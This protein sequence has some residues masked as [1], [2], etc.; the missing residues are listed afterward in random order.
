[1]SNVSLTI[2][3][4]GNLPALITSLTVCKPLKLKL[5][6]RLMLEKPLGASGI[7]FNSQWRYEISTIEITRRQ[8][9]ARS[10]CV[11]ICLL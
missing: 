11:D 1:M 8:T 5:K 4:A 10:S 7:T 6:L 3:M 9:F 2:I